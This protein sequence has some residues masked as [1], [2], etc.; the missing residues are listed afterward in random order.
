MQFKKHLPQIAMAV[1]LIGCLTLLLIPQGCMT[2]STPVV[3]SSTNSAGLVTLMTNT[4]TTVNQ[5]NLALDS[6]ILQGAVTVYLSVAV[7]KDPSIVPALKDAQLGLTGVL[8]GA[9]TNSVSQ[10][11]TALKQSSNPTLAAAMA[12]IVNDISVY[13]QAMLA[14]YG[15]TVSGQISIAFAQAVNGG[16]AVVLVGK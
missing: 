7:N 6:A 13:E 16:L 15:T 2:S 10:I 4:V 3:T 1:F 12:P 14:K 9:N 11:L 5:A 8:N